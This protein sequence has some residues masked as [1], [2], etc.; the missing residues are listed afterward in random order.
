MKEFVV[1]GVIADCWLRLQRNGREEVRGAK[2]IEGRRLKI[3]D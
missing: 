3:E 2:K 1:V